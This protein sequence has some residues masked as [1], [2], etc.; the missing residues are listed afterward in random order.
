MPLVTFGFDDWATIGVAGAKGRV[1]AQPATVTVGDR[2]VTTRSVP[3]ELDSTG[4]GSRLFDV[5]PPGEAVA[6]T[7]DVPAAKLGTVYVQIPE[8]DEISFGDLFNNH[9][10]SKDTLTTLPAAPTVGATIAELQATIAALQTTITA[11]ETKPIYP[12]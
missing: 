9:Q 12:S 11:L 4:S 5:T 6:F 3:V 1:F 10:V 2:V 8:Q 7:V